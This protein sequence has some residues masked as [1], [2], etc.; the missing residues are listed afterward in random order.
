[1][2]GSSRYA[3]INTENIRFEHFIDALFASKMTPGDMKTEVRGYVAALE[4][5]YTDTIKGLRAQI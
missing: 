5:N 3:H 2:L 4:T 1:M